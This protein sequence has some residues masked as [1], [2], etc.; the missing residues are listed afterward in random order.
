[1]FA[2][3]LQG[4]ATIAE[5]VRGLPGLGAFRAQISPAAIARPSARTN[6][7]ERDPQAGLT[8]CAPLGI[9]VTKQA[10]RKFIEAREQAAIAAVPTIRERVLNTAGAAEGIRSFVERRAAMFTGR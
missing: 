10:S 9:Q 4:A 7:S 1:M 8:D 2:R 6:G 3:A 5:N